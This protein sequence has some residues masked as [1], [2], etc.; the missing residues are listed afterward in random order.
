M[1]LYEFS[2]VK[3]W[4]RLHKIHWVI[5]FADSC[6]SPSMKI[7]IEWLRCWNR[8]FWG[9]MICTL[10]HIIWG[11]VHSCCSFNMFMLKMTWLWDINITTSKHVQYLLIYL[12]YTACIHDYTF[13]TAS[14]QC[15]QVVA[16]G[17]AGIWYPSKFI[18]SNVRFQTFAG[19]EDSEPT[20]MMQ[21]QGS[22]QCKYMSKLYNANT[23]YVYIYIYYMNTYLYM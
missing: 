19:R 8:A 14:H 7:R 15:L 10:L 1:I 23:V 9:W 3:R 11:Y 12:Y 21:I 6:S 4:N 13:C 5:A 20:E 17:T 2:Y 18:S 16:L 22:L